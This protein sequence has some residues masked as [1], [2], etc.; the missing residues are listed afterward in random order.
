[1]AICKKRYQFFTANYWCVISERKKLLKKF[2]KL[3]CSNILTQQFHNTQMKMYI[4]FVHVVCRALLYIK[5]P[6]NT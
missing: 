4:Q 3:V 2:V 1:M 5:T 6:K